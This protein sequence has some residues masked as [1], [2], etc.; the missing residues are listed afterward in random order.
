MVHLARERANLRAPR[1]AV[2]LQVGGWKRD[3]VTSIPRRTAYR[4]QIRIT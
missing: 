4:V 1:N 2:S 3:N